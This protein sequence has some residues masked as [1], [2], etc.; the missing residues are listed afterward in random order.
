MGAKRHIWNY[1]IFG[2][3]VIITSRLERLAGH[4]NRASVL[5]S[6][7]TCAELRRL[8]PALASLFR[9][10]GPV[11]IRGIQEPLEIHELG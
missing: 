5:I 4:E 10:T 6:E 2:R 9:S 3:E 11:S 8:D 7:S 1:S